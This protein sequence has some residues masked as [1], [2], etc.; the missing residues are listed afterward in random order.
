[1]KTKELNI[2]KIYKLLARVFKKNNSNNTVITITVY[3]ERLFIY[4]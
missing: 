3:S 4:K 1:M 2:K